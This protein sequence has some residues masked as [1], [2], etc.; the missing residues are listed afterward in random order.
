MC[1]CGCC[2]GSVS[3]YPQLTLI[4][5]SLSFFVTPKSSPGSFP[6]PWHQEVELASWSKHNKRP[7]TDHTP[8]SGPRL[9]RKKACLAVAMSVSFSFSLNVSDSTLRYLGLC[10]LH[11]GILSQFVP[12]SAGQPVFLSLCRAAVFAWRLP[13][14]LANGMTSSQPLITQWG[15]MHISIYT[16]LCTIVPCFSKCSGSP[17]DSELSEPLVLRNRINYYLHRMLHEI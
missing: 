5:P 17:S 1:A 8:N 16:Y 10:V 12:L 13:R 2:Y 3:V 9:K 15:W 14:C 4:P 11:D 6:S 7:I